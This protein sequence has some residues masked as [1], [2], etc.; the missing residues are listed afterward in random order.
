M[1]R[2]LTLGFALVFS[3]STVHA[4]PGPTGSSLA[5]Q[6]NGAGQYLSNA[7]FCTLTDNFGIEAWVM[8]YA[9][10]AGNGI[11]AYNGDT[12]LDGWGLL[13]SGGTFSG[14]LGGVTLVGSAPA[15]PYVWT[16]LA[17]V[18]DNGTSTFYV[19]GV[20]A[21]TNAGAPAAP[22]GGFALGA[23]PQSPTC[24]FFNGAIDEV[25][26]FTFAPGEFKACD[27]WFNIPSPQLIQPVVPDSGAFSFSFRNSAA[28]PY[29]VLVTTNLALPLGNWSVAGAPVP[30]GGDLFEFT[31]TMATNSPQRYYLLRFP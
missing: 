3:V 19:N 9:A 2:I 8:P 25:R 7:V 21:G 12:G 4:S 30:A 27:L 23:P 11:I 10:N 22:T 18:R 31:D 20:A 14:D 26:L 28:V 13:Q 6:F 16:H 17:L 1:T 24:Q 29:E 15:T 5:C